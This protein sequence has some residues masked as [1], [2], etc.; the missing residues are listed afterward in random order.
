M[1]RSLVGCG[2][3]G[4]VARKHSYTA[5]GGRCPDCLQPLR[6]V[7]LREARDLAY[8]RHMTAR[9]DDARV[10]VAEVRLAREAFLSTPEESARASDTQQ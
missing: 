1:T 8:R 6:R 5:A 2:S 3:C 9:K 7:S 4:F 10:E